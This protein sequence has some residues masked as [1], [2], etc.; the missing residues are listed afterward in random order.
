MQNLK[1]RKFEIEETVIN[2][3][4]IMIDYNRKKLKNITIS[5]TTTTATTT[6]Y[7]NNA[8]EV[9]LLT[10]SFILTRGSTL[11]KRLFVNNTFEFDVTK[12]VLFNRLEF[13]KPSVN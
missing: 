6:N 12:F 3:S 5:T 11:L 9:L 1:R 2:K 13:V 10:S 8:I 4:I 7:K